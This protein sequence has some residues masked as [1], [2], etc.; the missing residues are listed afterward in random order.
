MLRRRD[1]RAMHR[2]AARGRFPRGSRIRVYPARNQPGVF[3]RDLH[4]KALPS[5]NAV[6]AYAGGWW[7]THCV[8]AGTPPRGAG[9]VP[10][11]PIQARRRPGDEQLPQGCERGPGAAPPRPRAL[12]RRASA[13]PAGHAVRAF[14]CRRW[15]TGARLDGARELGYPHFGTA[16]KCRYALVLPLLAAGARVLLHSLA[17]PRP[18]PDPPVSICHKS[19]RATRP[20]VRTRGPLLA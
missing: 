11:T 6:F 4:F 5:R 2:H 12:P 3:L 19:L 8:Q 20:H 14:H 1:P 15:N 17:R 10:W 7:G 13:G 18:A 16:T 9:P